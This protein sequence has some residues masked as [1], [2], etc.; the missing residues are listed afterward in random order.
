MRAGSHVIVRKHTV[1]QTL[2]LQHRCCS[3]CFDRRLA[4]NRMNEVIQAVRYC[5]AAV[6]CFLGQLADNALDVAAVQIRRYAAYSKAVLAKRVDRKSGFAN[7]LQLRLYCCRLLAGQFDHDRRQKLLLRHFCLSTELIEQNSLVSRM[8]VDEQ[9][10][11]FI[12]R[13][14]VG[15]EALADDARAVINRLIYRLLLHSFLRIRLRLR[16]IDQISLGCRIVCMFRCFFIRLWTFGRESCN[17]S[18][19]FDL[20][21]RILQLTR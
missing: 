16:N 20:F 12:L 1:T 14:D 19:R 9:Q 8:F 4:C 17:I 18:L 2:Q 15:A 13:Y 10:T 7:I 3:A 11:V 6:H 5:C 21:L